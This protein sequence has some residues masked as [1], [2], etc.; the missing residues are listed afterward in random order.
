LYK[1]AASSSVAERAGTET[2]SAAAASGIPIKAAAN[3]LIIAVTFPANYD[4]SNPPGAIWTWQRPC[5][6]SS[7]EKYNLARSALRSFAQA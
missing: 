2:K 5:R 4:L 3:F 1:A 7:V 6:A